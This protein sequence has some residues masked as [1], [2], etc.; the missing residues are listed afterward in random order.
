MSTPS[1]YESYY[2][3]KFKR[4]H[5]ARIEQYN[6][7]LKNFG[8]LAHVFRHKGDSRLTKHK[9]VF[10]AINVMVA[11]QLKNGFPLFDP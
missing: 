10:Q 4:R 5:R 8:I 2:V 1:Q 6:G 7:R 9:V 11:L 3:K